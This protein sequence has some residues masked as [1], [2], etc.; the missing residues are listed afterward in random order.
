MEQVLQLLGGVRVQDQLVR[1]IIRA[2]ER[3]ELEGLRYLVGCPFARFD[4]RRVEGAIGPS[5]GN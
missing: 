5:L 3:I 2:D 1:P 4:G